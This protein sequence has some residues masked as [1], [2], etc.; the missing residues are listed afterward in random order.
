MIGGLNVAAI[1]FA[2]TACAVT[3][4]AVELLDRALHWIERRTVRDRQPQRDEAQL[5]LALLCEQMHERSGPLPRWLVWRSPIRSPLNR[6]FVRTPVRPISAG[7][8][9][10]HRMNSLVRFLGW[11]VLS[12]PDRKTH[13][14][15][16]A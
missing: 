14:P 1:A 6:F 2:L 15:R 13:Q 5:L 4:A 8:D 3:I 7:W 9:K 16:R 11:P 12:A 10:R